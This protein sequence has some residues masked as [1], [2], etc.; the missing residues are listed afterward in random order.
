MLNKEQIEFIA[1]EM[2]ITNESVSTMV[3]SNTQEIKRLCV[4]IMGEEYAAE[5][6][7]SAYRYYTAEEILEKVLTH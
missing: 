2:G 4:R 1:N 3:I 6:G 7:I 5:G